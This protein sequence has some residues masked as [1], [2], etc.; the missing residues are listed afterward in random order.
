MGDNVQEVLVKIPR[1]QSRRLKIERFFDK[2][3]VRRKASKSSNQVGRTCFTHH[4][5]IEDSSEP[6]SINL[7]NIPRGVIPIEF[8]QEEIQ[9][10]YDKGF[11]EGQMSEMAVARAEI[12]SF[13]EKMRTME[14]VIQEFEKKNND[15][16]NQLHDSVLNI[17]EKVSL[18]IMRAESLTNSDSIKQ[19]IG[20]VIDE[21][22]DS[23]I[24]SI[25]LNPETIKQIKETD[26]RL[27]EFESPNVELIDD[28][29][30]DMNDC[31]INTDS[32]NLE[33]RITEE[34]SN[35][36][37]KLKTDFQ[38]TKVRK[39]DEEIK[40]LEKGIPKKDV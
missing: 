28:E 40:R 5:V 17:A 6:I 29:S 30:L 27:L 36:M 16:L 31:I 3:Q 11:E 21:A 34:L 15:L 10:S 38:T 18:H 20:K 13:V 7:D 22:R 35:M 24:I 19:R 33:A 39:R 2:G 37:Q 26:T 23:K 14:G 9:K 4:F 32:G 12:N 1:T 8:A 25:R